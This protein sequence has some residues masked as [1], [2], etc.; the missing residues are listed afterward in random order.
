MIVIMS[1]DSHIKLPHIVCHSSHPLETHSKL[2]PY[3][4]VIIIILII[5]IIIILILSIILS[6]LLIIIIILIILVSHFKNVNRE[7]FQLINPVWCQDVWCLDVHMYG[8]LICLVIS[9]NCIFNI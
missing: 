9:V 7:Y 8:R 4:V 6:I 3:D 2:I 5:L 1:F